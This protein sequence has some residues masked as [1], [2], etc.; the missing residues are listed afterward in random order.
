MLDIAQSCATSC[1]YYTLYERP[2]SNYQRTSKRYLSLE[3]SGIASRE[4]IGHRLNG[5]YCLCLQDCEW[6]PNKRSHDAT[7]VGTNRIHGKKCTI[8]RQNFYNVSYFTEYSRNSRKEF[9]KL[10]GHTDVISRC[11]ANANE[12][13]SEQQIF[14]T[15]SQNSRQLMPTT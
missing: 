4:Y 10:T 7:C 2:R 6:V 13:I 11:C 14:T 9:R 5:L 12:E 1:I 3:K 8:S 15:L